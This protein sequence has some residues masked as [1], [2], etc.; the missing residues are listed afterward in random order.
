[1]TITAYFT[2]HDKDNLVLNGDFEMNK[3]P[4]AQDSLS[5]EEQF[6]C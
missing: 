5:D 4:S 6:Q 2:A 3:N 1:M